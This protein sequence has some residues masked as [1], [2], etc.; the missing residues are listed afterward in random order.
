MFYLFKMGK[1]VEIIELKGMFYEEELCVV[2]CYY[3]EVVV[4]IIKYL[5]EVKQLS[6]YF[7]IMNKQVLKVVDG[8]FFYILKGEIFG[9]VGEFG[10][11]KLIVG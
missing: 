4:M 2:W 3:Q 9:F 7:L 5:L 11:G 10:C 6:K 8:V 1:I